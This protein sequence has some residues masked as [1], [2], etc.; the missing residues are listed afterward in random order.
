[1]YVDDYKYSVNGK[2]QRR[3]LVRHNYR[4]NGKV[5]QKTIANITGLPD[6]IIE[7]IKI[8]LK[9]GEGF[10]YIEEL[11]NGNF[12]H[13]K[14]IGS[15]FVLQKIINEIGITKALGT[16][17]NSKLISWLVMARLL[18]Q[19][20][21]LSSVRLAQIHAGCE[22]L[23]IE[24]L[25]EDLLYSSMDWLY[26]QKDK[27]EQKLFKQ[28]QQNK[29]NQ[30]KNPHLF[31]YDVS[32]SYLEGEHNELAAWGYNRDKK[33][34]KMQIVYGLLTDEHGEPLGVEVF[35]G[36]TVDIKTFESQIIKIKE[37]FNCTRVTLVGDKGMIKSF[38][39]ND[40]HKAGFNYITSISKAEIETLIKKE[41]FQLELFTDELIEISD[42]GVRYVLHRNPVRAIEIQK[43]RDSKIVKIKAKI[44][45]SNNYLKEHPKAKPEVQE[46][47]IK[48][49]ISRV[50]LSKAIEVFCDIKD[51]H[52][53][54]VINDE[55]IQHLSRLD[56]C[57][58]IKTDLLKSEID[59]KTIHTRYKSLAEVEWAFRTE[60]SLL[61]IR[62]IYLRNRERTI[63]HVF[64]CML[65]YKVEKYLRE[66]WKDIDLTVEEGIKMLGQIIGSKIKIGEKELVRLPNPNKSCNELL[67]ALNIT[68]PSMI[69][70]KECVV[71][72]KRKLPQR[73]K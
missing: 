56:G 28:W 39:I 38:Q 54:I 17:E 8:G 41:T 51:R 47:N 71:N 70:Y 36:N 14:T 69:S 60:K 37:K 62:P 11:S 64:I 31:L 35:E 58:V 32:S 26:E 18:E 20:S 44:T 72:T 49:Y 7:L 68:M 25:N 52:L 40:L 48:N 43:N 24:E 23:K 10:K 27:T 4:E 67:N 29:K 30:H 2:P 73:R 33:A 63:A 57:Y 3:A 61:E 46:K 45:N 53:V 19:G 42:N 59:T 16:D 13:T 1:M 6:H 34:G 50:N 66:Y 15:V 65:A 21:R 55:A 12:S 5:K 22:L 9:S